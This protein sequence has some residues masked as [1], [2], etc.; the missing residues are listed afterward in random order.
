MVALAGWRTRTLTAPGAL[1]AWT[2]GT[3][4]LYGTGWQGGAVLAAFFISSSLISRVATTPPLMDPKGHQRDHWQVFAN[5]AV[6]AAGA[7]VA[8]IEPD[9]GLWLVTAS[10]AA[11]ASDTWATSVGSRSPVSPRLIW[12]QRVVPA[13]SNGGITLLGTVGS[14]GGAMIVAGTA[15]IAAG[16]PMLLPIGTLIGFFGMVVDSTLGAL[17]QG[18]FHCPSC[19]VPSEWRIHRCGS[20]TVQEGGLAWLN[21]DGVNFLATLVAAAAAWAT[22]QWMDS[23]G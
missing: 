19:Q 4:V 23:P 20:A 12:N 6:A 15:A 2:V 21:N 10:L 9:L 13:G 14:V 18:R 17:L 11:A 7:T 16:R 22:W 8:T 3:A 1:A 5:G